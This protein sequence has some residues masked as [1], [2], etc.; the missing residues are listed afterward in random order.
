M[1]VC[2]EAGGFHFDMANLNSQANW[3]MEEAKAGK[4]LALLCASCLLI[5]QCHVV[6]REQ[7]EVGNF[8]I[9]SI[10]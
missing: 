5:K 6:M 9:K 7:F 10:Q 1:L 8:I 4:C 2:R 3:Y